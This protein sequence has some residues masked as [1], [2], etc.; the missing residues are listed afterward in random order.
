MSNLPFKELDEAV[1]RPGRMYRR[2][3]FDAFNKEEATRVLT[4]LEGDPE[5]QLGT[6]PPRK[7]TLAHLYAL[8][9]AHK[10]GE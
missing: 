2:L 9:K 10:R 7:L 8:A 5:T 3:Q 4:R 6:T 1:K